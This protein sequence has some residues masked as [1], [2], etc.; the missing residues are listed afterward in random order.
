MKSLLKGL[1]ISI[2]VGVLVVLFLRSL[3]R[4]TLEY[5]FLYALPAGVVCLLLIWRVL[6]PETPPKQP[7]PLRVVLMRNVLSRP[8]R[9]PPVPVEKKKIFQRDWEARKAR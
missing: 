8:E 5:L 3:D 1:M 2:C 6:D 9:R 4:A 7:Q